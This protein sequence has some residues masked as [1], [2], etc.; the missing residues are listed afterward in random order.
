MQVLDDEKHDNNSI[1][2]N[3]LD[4]GPTRTPLRAAACPNEDPNTLKTP[5]A[6]MPLYLWLMGPDSIGTTGQALSFEAD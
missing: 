6:L 3:S 1:R 4:P 2:F 5:E